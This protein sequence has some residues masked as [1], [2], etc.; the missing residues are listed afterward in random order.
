MDSKREP[1]IAPYEGLVHRTAQLFSPLLGIEQ[2]DLCQELRVKVWK[3]LRTYDPA[4]SSLPEQRYVYGCLTNYIKDLK[5]ESARRAARERPVE[6]IEDQVT[7]FGSLA[8]FELRYLH[9]THDEVFQTVEEAGFILPSTITEP[10]TRVL[11]RLL[12][13]YSQPEIAEEMGLRREAVKRLVVSLRDKLAD[14][15]PS[16]PVAALPA[17]VPVRATALAA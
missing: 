6:H 17:P 1:D 12:H 5:K 2:E 8:A 11:L 15:R 10:E 3:V 7:A 16:S 4:R 9:V 13:G 14:W